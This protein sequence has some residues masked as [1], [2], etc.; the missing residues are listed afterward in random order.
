M[1]LEQSS[2]HTV[3][4]QRL[5]SGLRMGTPKDCQPSTP[6]IRTRQLAV[7]IETD[8]ISKTQ[9]LPDKGIRVAE[10]GDVGSSHNTEWLNMQI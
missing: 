10:P 4:H 7:P 6:E 2:T 1:R 9:S 5:M 8:R 3:F